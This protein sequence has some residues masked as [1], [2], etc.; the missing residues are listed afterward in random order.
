MTRDLAT[1]RQV[2]AAAPGNSTWLAANAGSGKTR[3]LTDRVARLLLEGVLPEHILCLTY[4]KAAASE[5]QNRLFRRLGAWAMLDGQALRAELRTLGVETALDDDFLRQ[6]RTLFA[7]AIETPGGLRIQTIHSFCASLLRRFPLEAKVSPQFQEMVDRSGELLRAEI[8]DQIAEGPDAHL[9]QAIAPY[10]SGDDAESLLAELTRHRDAFALAPS[11]A[12]IHAAYGLAEGLTLDTLPAQVFLGSEQALFQ[13]IIPHLRA[14]GVYDNALADALEAGIAADPA[15]LTA[16]EAAVLTK[17]GTVSKR[18][19]SKG[20]TKNA[21]DLAE[22]FAQLMQR[23]EDARQTRLALLAAQRDIA[24]HRFAARFIPTYELAK[25]RRGWLDF[26]DLITRARDLLNDPKVAAWVLYKLDG[27]IDHILVDEAQDTSPVQWQVIE[28]LAQEF[29]SGEGARTD[30]RRTIFVVG[31]KKQSI[32]SFQGADPAEFDRM[33]DEFRERLLHTDAPLAAME[34]EHSFR[35]ADP[36]LRLVDCTFDNA[37]E[38][39]FVPDQKHRAFKDR[40]PGRVDLWPVVETVKEDVDAEWFDPVD[41]V[42][43]QHHTVILAKRIADFIHGTIQAETPLPIEKGHSGD[44]QARPVHAGDFL[45][46]V[47]AR[48]RL[49]SEIIRACKQKGLPI[50]G[51]DRL[52]VMAELA[53][54]D[55]MALL[56]FLST[57]EDDLSLATALR[58]PLFGISEQALFDLAHRRTERY[59]WEALR[60]NREK[61]PAVMQVIDDLRDQTDFLR[62]YDLIERILTRHKG[63]QLLV[64]R[65][66]AE[67]ED[68]INALLVQALAYERS[69]IPSLTGFLQW[70]EA[71]NLEIKRAAE[72]AGKTLR[73][74]TVHGAKGLEAPIVIM[75]DCAERR[76]TLRASLLRDQ[77]GLLWKQTS[78]ALPARHA[79]AIQ[80]AKD[81]EAREHDR[82]LYVGLTRAEKWLIVAAS[83]DTGKSGAA[84]YDK[85]ARGMQGVGAEETLFDFG[86][87][88]S[89]KG[90]T[91]RHG[92]WSAL[93]MTRPTTVAD[94]SPDLP[95]HLTRAA[96]LPQIP[97]ATVSPSDLGGPKALPGDEGD[98]EGAA[99]ERGSLIHELLELLAPLPAET[100]ESAGQA[101]LTAKGFW[102]GAEPLLRES[103]G[104]L[105]APDLAPFFAPGTLAEVPVAADLP[106]I[107]RIHGIIDRLVVTPDKIT[108]LDFKSNRVLPANAD[109]VPEGLK[110]QMGA[111]ARALG[112]IY[113]GR[114]IETGLIWTINAQY[115]PLP[116]DTVTQALGRM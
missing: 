58:S 23:V 56:S 15:G 17:A 100:R 37:Q 57:P 29:T 49:F 21:P 114:E 62:P 20:L 98:D 50:A 46:L 74:M 95:S 35:S 64:G 86:D 91:V 108:V 33:R 76:D 66:G 99:K 72:S 79:A 19:L 78:D 109:A 106:G 101:L 6:A 60:K 104:V 71:D 68:G 112:Q 16:L 88:G 85:V 63:R 2:D 70:A 54:R 31:D 30:T 5:M 113:P 84:W 25:Q 103:L 77:G 28:R 116:H 93:D 48:S 11:D 92:D 40:M 1:Q 45:I 4:T 52:K 39:G 51:A 14:S 61:F 9:V 87:L 96:P 59:L 53:V 3:V 10:I 32:Y 80:D 41:R 43:V 22:A 36:I 97:P 18:L 24:L 73:V 26:D 111:Y 27:G 13:Q 34:L 82:L 42:G 38:S 55:I 107:G 7:R 8:L 90:L 69:D 89:G 105:Q 44:Y 102:P 110:R 67:A 83:G 94:L 65:L 115:M 81:A 47:R 12:A 75:P